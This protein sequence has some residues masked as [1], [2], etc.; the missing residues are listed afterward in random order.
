ME[1]ELCPNFQHPF[2]CLVSGMTQ[3]GKSEWVY[4]LL[5]SDKIEP[6]PEKILYCYGE[7]SAQFEKYD[8]PV[9]FHR[10]MPTNLEEIIGGDGGNKRQ[11]IILDDLMHEVDGGETGK[12]VAS[13]FTRGSHHRNISIVLVVQNL[14]HQ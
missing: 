5:H 14:F 7:Q 12:L 2:T 4:R 8:R 6:P 13:L 11:L 9:T 3:S 10:G 1:L